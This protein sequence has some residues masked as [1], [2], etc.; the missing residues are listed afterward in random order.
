VQARAAARAGAAIEALLPDARV[1]TGE[2]GV[3][4][5]GRGMRRRWLSD[6]RLRWISEWLR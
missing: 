2:S 6:A 4:I 5:E 1:S 3:T